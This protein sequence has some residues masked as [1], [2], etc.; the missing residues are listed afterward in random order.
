MRKMLAARLPIQTQRSGRSPEVPADEASPLNVRNRTRHLRS[1]ADMPPATSMP[2][3]GHMISSRMSTRRASAAISPC[4]SSHGGAITQPMMP[5]ISM[6]ALI[7]RPMIMPEP[8]LS[9]DTPNPRPTRAENA[10]TASGMLS[11]IHRSCVARNA[12]PES[13]ERAESS[14]MPTCVPARRASRA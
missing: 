11:T 5:P 8:M 13:T 4:D 6:L 7:R 14:R 2:T 1:N 3:A 9:S 10:F 12:S